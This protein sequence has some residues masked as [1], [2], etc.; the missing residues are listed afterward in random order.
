VPLDPA[1]I[2]AVETL[3]THSIGAIAKVVVRRALPKC[4][5][6]D[7]FLVLISRS[8]ES[9]SDRTQFLKNVAGLS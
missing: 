8:I 9:T 3:L 2:A 6:R 5:S 7:D 4:S 1:F